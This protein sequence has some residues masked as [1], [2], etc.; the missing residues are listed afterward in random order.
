VKGLDEDSEVGHLVRGGDLGVGG[1]N[2]KKGGGLGRHKESNG[3]P[4]QDGVGFGTRAG[5]TEREEEYS[6]GGGTRGR[7][8]TRDSCFL[9]SRKKDRN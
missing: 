1:G 6:S 7:M 2:R 3:M 4:E 9:Q 8:V 5:L